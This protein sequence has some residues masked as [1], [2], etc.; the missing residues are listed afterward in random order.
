ML[1]QHVLAVPGELAAERLEGGAGFG[2]R[3]AW[4]HG[5]LAVAGDG[6]VHWRGE[7][8]AAEQ[9]LAVWAGRGQDVDD[10]LDP[11]PLWGSAFEENSIT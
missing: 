7:S 2:A 10:T 4:V 9:V 8:W 3:L 1:P 5:E 11:N 6:A